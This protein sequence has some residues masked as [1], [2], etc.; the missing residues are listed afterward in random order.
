MNF[1]QMFLWCT[2]PMMLLFKLLVRGRRECRLS[3]RSFASSA[4]H[5]CRDLKRIIRGNW[6]RE[7][8]CR[9]CFVRRTTL[10]C[11]EASKKICVNALDHELFSQGFCGF[12][13]RF[14]R[15]SDNAVD[16]ILVTRSSLMPVP[17]NSQDVH[18]FSGRGNLEARTGEGIR[19]SVQVRSTA[20]STF[21]PF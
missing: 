21:S 15:Q 12:L 14:S 4:V 13:V 20:C 16:D 19:S 11:F 1:P 6:L 18:G 9:R 3:V 2:S 10:C 7:E 5:V 17:I 8:I